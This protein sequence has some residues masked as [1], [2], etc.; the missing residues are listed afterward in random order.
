MTV[1][2]TGGDSDCES[3]VPGQL[4]STGPDIIDSPGVRR[5]TGGWALAAGRAGPRRRRRHCGSGSVALPGR[6]IFKL[7]VTVNRA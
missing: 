6:M 4:E 7:R 3:R 1:R 5:A 2:V